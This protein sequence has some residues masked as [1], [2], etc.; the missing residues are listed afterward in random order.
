MSKPRGVD[1]EL[2]ERQEQPADDSGI[3]LPNCV[4]INGVDVAIPA[5]SEIRFSKVTESEAFT[6]TLTLYVRSL[7]VRTENAP[8]TMLPAPF[9]PAAHALF[10][11][12]AGSTD[13]H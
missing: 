6:V 9:P 5:D 10:T 1:I 12:P 7:S 4:R 3:V 13:A 2:V 8:A 11:R